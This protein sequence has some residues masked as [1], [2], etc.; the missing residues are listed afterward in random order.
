MVITW[1][2]NLE[3]EYNEHQAQIKGHKVIVFRNMD[4]SE[5]YCEIDDGPMFSLH[6][7]SLNEALKNAEKEAKNWD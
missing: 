4:G 2:E 5:W 3:G 1:T 6:A 7:Q